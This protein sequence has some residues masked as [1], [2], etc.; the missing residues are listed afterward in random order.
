MVKISAL[1]SQQRL[2]QLAKSQLG[3]ISSV[4]PAAQNDSPE[5]QGNFSDKHHHLAA[6]SG[7]A[8]SAVLTLAQRAERR[9]QMQRE[10]QQ[11]NLESIMTLALE[12]C[13]DQV[14][15]QDVDPDWFQQF[16]ELVLEISNKSM[17]QL[18]AKIL[19]GEIA[20]P[21]KFSLK[22]LHT[23]KRMSYKEALALQQAVN[24]SCKTRQDPS[25]RIYFGYIRKPSLWRVLT[26][27]S[28]AVL[29]L[30]QFGLSYPQILSLIDIGLL[31]SSEIE[32]G[33]L[34]AGQILNWQ[35]QQLHL[36][37]TI[38]SK[39]VVLQYYKYTASGA[40]LLPLLSSQPN[41]AYISAL[42]QLLAGIISFS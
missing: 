10:R 32:S 17:Q 19:A 37:G 16:C 25:A 3:S 30:N 31:H 34:P 8:S 21:G 29:N 4:S 20:S 11:Y 9:L 24:L 27:K 36:N 42:K 14:S 2:L 7:A 5:Q 41:Q 33:E 18:W 6:R 22:T 15:T 35:Y 39:G 13:T 28:R 1:N 12:Y 40:E 23:L 26:G 38:T